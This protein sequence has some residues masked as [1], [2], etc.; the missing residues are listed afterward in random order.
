MTGIRRSGV[1]L[2]VPGLLN[3]VEERIVKI[4]DDYAS[5]SRHHGRW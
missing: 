5:L 3:F 4:E 2:A 1:G